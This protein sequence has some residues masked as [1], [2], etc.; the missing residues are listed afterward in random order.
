MIGGQIQIERLAQGQG[1]GPVLTW[2]SICWKTA[3]SRLFQQSLGLPR[4]GQLAGP[5]IQ[6]LPMTWAGVRGPLGAAS[7]SL[8]RIGW[9]FDEPFVLYSDMGTKFVLTDASP[10]MITYHMV[11]SWGRMRARAAATAIGLHG[12]RL[13]ATILHQSLQP[14]GGA[15]HFV[16]LRAF[17]TQSIWSHSRLYAVGYDVNPQCCHCGAPN[18]SLHH[19]LFECESTNSMRQDFLEDG[20]IAHLR[21]SDHMRALAL[22]FQVVPDWEPER[23]AGLG[24]E[25]DSCDSW[26]ITGAPAETYMRGEVFTDG[27]CFKHGPPQWHRTGW[28]VCKVSE[29]GV[30]LAYIRGRAGKQVPQTSP[31]TEHLGVLKASTISDEVEKVNS[32]YKGLDRIE[33]M[34]PECILHHRSLYA[35]LKRRIMALK[36][37]RMQVEHCKA[38]V[39]PD[40]CTNRRDKFL[41]LGNQ[42]ADRVA[43]QAA[44]QPPPNRDSTSSSGGSAS[45]AS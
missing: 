19:R 39:N 45:G 15:G 31:A 36:P 3:N 6:H 25:A 23:P 37:P 8:A 26:S 20:D 9:R 32:D 24:V 42:H 4:L 17:A 5:V 28:A 35:G 30:L 13:D 10:T 40:L 14:K 29:D 11:I 16:L 2:A 41:A 18:D 44:A 7:R 1:L 12:A 38:H 34:P 43:Q 27:S 22:G 21:D 33:T